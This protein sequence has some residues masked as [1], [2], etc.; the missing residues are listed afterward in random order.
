[1]KVGIMQPYFSPYIGYW[2]LMNA[3]DTYVIY[4]DVNYIKGG[5]INRNRILV[6][7]KPTYFNVPMIGASSNKKIN[8]VSVNNDP[9][10]IE[11]N[12]H[13]IRDAYHKAPYYSDAYPCIEKILQTNE[14]NLAKYLERS[15]RIIVKY[16]NI[17]TK[18][19]LS[20][21]MQKDCTLK[22]K[23]KVIHIC[24]LLE[25][26]EYYNAIGGQDLYDYTEFQEQGIEL[27]F[28]KTGD[29][30][31]EQYGNPAEKNLSILDVMMF[32]SPENIQKMLN[33]YILL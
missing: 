5:W 29:V 4:D 21:S 23:E 8:E 33:E 25:A 28:L 12:L 19:I 2:Q 6:N 13:M 7:G 22:G 24:H 18:L 14:S 20:S 10:L 11:K 3:V 15:I 32:N 31:Y 17:T 27:K 16:L 26:T 1:M 9:R 30:Y